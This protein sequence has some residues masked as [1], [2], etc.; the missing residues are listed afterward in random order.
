M[1]LFGVTELK[2]STKTAFFANRKHLNLCHFLLQHAW[3]TFTN[4]VQ[5]VSQYLKHILGQ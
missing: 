4:L 5:L 2:K 3:L 1:L